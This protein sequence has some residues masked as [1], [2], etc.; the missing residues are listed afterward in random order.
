MGGD[1]GPYI[2]SDR[3]HLYREYALQLIKSGHAYYCFCNK[4]RLEEL[5]RIQKAS[6]MA[7]KYDGHCRN[8]SP[9]E[10]QQKLDAKEPYVI[11]QKLP[12]TGQTSFHDEVFGDIVFENSELDDQILIKS[13]GMPTYNFANVVDDHLMKIS[14]V[15]RGSE[16]LSST[17]KYNLLYQAF[18]WDLPTYIH[19]SP[20]M[21]NATE[22]LSKRNGDASFEELAQ[23]GYLP[24]A[25][26]NYIALLGWSPKG[27]QEIFSL[28]ELVQE[29]STSGISKSP[30]IFD[31]KKLKAINGEQIRRLSESDFIKHALPQIRSTCKRE[32]LDLSLLTRMLQ[33]RTEL[34]QD[35]PE[36]IDFIDQLPDYDNN[37][38]SHKKMKTT[39]ENALQALEAILPVLEKLEEWT[40]DGIHQ[41]LFALIAQLGLKNGQILWPLRVALSGKQFTPGGGIEICALLGKEESMR[42]LKDGIFRLKAAVNP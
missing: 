20:V 7:P 37:L 27:E 25:I 21:K 10:I 38:Y 30:A 26:V 39:E 12:R 23:K 35:I 18:G 14:H 31:V 8:L 4:E 40:E 16:Y 22:K 17:P 15:I 32:N 11:R 6:S 2:Q 13:D 5:K 33:P 42:R 36:Q 3:M 34:F 1:Y 28:E 19:C 29:F 41:V 24:E 9:E